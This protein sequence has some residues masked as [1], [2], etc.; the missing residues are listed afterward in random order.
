MI[1]NSRTNKSFLFNT[2]SLYQF[3][4]VYLKSFLA[5]FF[6]VQLV[7]ASDVELGMDRP[8]VVN[9]LGRPKG[10]VSTGKKEIMYFERGKVELTDQKVSRVDLMSSQALRDIKY[11]QQ[12]E[13]LM[14]PR[15]LPKTRY[16]LFKVLET[17]AMCVMNGSKNNTGDY[18][19]FVGPDVSRKWDA[20]GDSYRDDLHWAG[21]HTYTNDE[22]IEKTLHCYSTQKDFAVK[23]VREKF[24]LY[25]D[26]PQETSRALSFGKRQD[27]SHSIMLAFG[28][29]F[30]VST[31]GYVLTSEHIVRKAEQIKIRTATG[32]YPARII[33]QDKF[34]DIALL[35]V[36]GQY[37]PLSFST[38]RVA[39]LGQTIFTIGFPMPD[40][41]GFSPKVTKGVVSS[42][43]GVLDDNR[44]YQFDAAIQPGNSGGALVDETGCVIGIVHGQIN[45]AMVIDEKGALPQN[46]NY[47]VK[48]S[49]ILAALNDHPEV[50][51]QLGKDGGT[52]D[53]SFEDAVERVRRATVLVVAY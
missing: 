8:T 13:M 48:K 29:G 12:A 22:G 49:Y 27:D 25:D 31:N 16:T 37:E 51:V 44:D 40:L 15:F 17:G 28:S 30:I 5:A 32:L 41:Q 10:Q 50:L 45:E 35:K 3:I 52:G 46:V 20:E 18:F 2:K 1:K 23:S 39:R 38:N 11:Q 34:N 42:L 4:S 47:A 7:R 26:P 9:I 19:F 24:N 21:T 33:L 6:C 53:L 36:E 43:K 14:A